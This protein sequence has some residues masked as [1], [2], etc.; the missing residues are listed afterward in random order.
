MYEKNL[1]LT[2]RYLLDDMYIE[3]TRI[4]ISYKEITY[5]YEKTHLT[6]V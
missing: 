4:R 1:K 2:C 5:V 3:L 6:V